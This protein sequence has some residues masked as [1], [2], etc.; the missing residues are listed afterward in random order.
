MF[1]GAEGDVVIVQP[2]VDLVAWFDPELVSQL[3]RDDDLPFGAD[4]VS[5]T[6]KY[7]SRETAGHHRRT[8]VAVKAQLRPPPPS[9]MQVRPHFSEWG[10]LLSVGA[11]TGFSAVRSAFSVL[12]RSTRCPDLGVLGAMSPQGRDLRVTSPKVTRPDVRSGYRLPVVPK[13]GGR[14]ER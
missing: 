8:R 10:L 4:A 14:G 7:N 1:G 2:E 13:P 3:F 5:H 12:E 6:V 11:S 9:N